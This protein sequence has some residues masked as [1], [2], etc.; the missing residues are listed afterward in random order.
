MKTNGA[1]T[2]SNRRILADVVAVTMSFMVLAMSAT[3]HAQA[4][5]PAPVEAAAVEVDGLRDLRPPVKPKPPL[6]APSLAYGVD[7][8]SIVQV[9]LGP[10]DVAALLEEDAARAR[11]DKVLRYGVGR[12]IVVGM[13]DGRWHEVPGEGSLWV[14]DVVAEAANGIRLHF[15]D[16]DMSPG[17]QLFVYA[18][19]QPER[20]A[21]PYS[22]RGI[23]GDGQ[24]WTPTRFGERLR[25][26]YFVPSTVTEDP[27]R[28]A[29]AIDR[30]QHIYHD[31]FGANNSVQTG[32]SPQERDSCD[33]PTD[34]PNAPAGGS[35][36]GACDGGGCTSATTLYPD[37]LFSTTSS[38][39]TTFTTCAYGGEHSRFWVESG[40]TYEW[41][42]CTGDGD[43]SCSWDSQFMLRDTSG[44]NI[45]YNDDWC[46]TQSKIRWMATFTGEVHLARLQ[47]ECTTNDACATLVWREAPCRID[48]TCYPAWDHETSAVGGIGYIDSDSLYCSGQLINNLASDWTPYWLTANHCLNTQAKAQSAEIYWLYQSATCNGAPPA[49]SSVPQSAVCTL[50]ATGMPTDYTLLMVDGE[51][52]TGLWWA[53]WTA[54]AI[55]DGTAAGGI[56]HPAG[57]HKQIS[58][59]SK[60]STTSTHHWINWSD[61]GTEGGSSGSGIFT[62]S[63][64]QLFG[65]LSGNVDDCYFQDNY[66]AFSVTYPDISNFMAGGS[67][68]VWEQ[69]DSCAD[70]VT[71]GSG[72]YPDLIVKGV[73]EDWYKIGIP[74]AQTLDVHVAFTDVW[75]D[76][77]I[78]LYDVCDGALVAS[79]ATTTDNESLSYQNCG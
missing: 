10:V 16:V 8:K 9:G 30:I 48:L 24:F 12:D 34:P 13:A 18:I 70:A 26:E 59:G 37:T 53:G 73:D 19:A 38:D 50:L 33:T 62:Q 75:G 63:G 31:S 68:D 39:W 43:A 22:N 11:L 29:F 44:N 4:R 42:A 7:V 78:E 58:F 51:L 6:Q 2:R 49:L 3:A 47:Y 32:G 57:S 76:I 15:V 27:R 1:A 21:G 45:C 20:L 5:S 55:A 77:D 56:H 64:R 28:P 66:G 25:V 35:R 61:G 74:T 71:A 46:G 54:A 17:A 52:P 60:S 41:S 14:V 23:H 69:N 79:S 65:Q 40:H 36:S 67:D 72:S